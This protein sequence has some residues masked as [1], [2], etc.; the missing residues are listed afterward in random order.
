M[1]LHDDEEE[2][3]KEGVYSG[4]GDNVGVEAVAEVDG[5]DVV[6]GAKLACA[7]RPRCTPQRRRRVPDSRQARGWG[8]GWGAT[9]HSKSLYIMVK[10]TWRKRLTAF[11]RTA[12]RYNHASPDMLRA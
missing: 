3:R 11:I 5:V 8:W 4:F 10:N 12:N 7:R 1:D 2:E 9:H 6:A